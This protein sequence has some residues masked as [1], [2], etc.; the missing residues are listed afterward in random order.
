MIPHKCGWLVNCFVLVLY[1]FGVVYY[2]TVLYP[3]ISY[4]FA[5]AILFCYP[6]CIRNV[7]GTTGCRPYWKTKT[8]IYFKC[9]W[10]SEISSCLQTC[11]VLC[12]CRSLGET[13]HLKAFTP[14][15]KVTN[16]GAFSSWNWKWLSGKWQGWRNSLHEF[17]LHKYFSRIKYY[18]PIG[19]LSVTATCRR[20][21]CG[22]MRAATI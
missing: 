9:V 16:R 2:W 19:K 20:A 3:W 7:Y 8:A 6:F 14:A 17:F 12:H 4:C 15:W 22:N 21:P 1:I 10:L 11:P 18:H 13:W 5:F